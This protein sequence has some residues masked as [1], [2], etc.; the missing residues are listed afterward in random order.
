MVFWPNKKQDVMPNSQKK[1]SEWLNEQLNQKWFKAS[2]MRARE[3]IRLLNAQASA[4]ARQSLGR[5]SRSKREDPKTVANFTATE[6]MDEMD[7][8]FSFCDDRLRPYTTSWL[9]LWL[10]TR[11]EVLKS[12]L[13][14]EWPFQ[15][16]LN[17]A[18]A[19]CEAFVEDWLLDWSITTVWSIFSLKDW[20][21]RNDRPKEE[22]K[23]WEKI[24]SDL[25]TEEILNQIEDKWFLE[26]IE[27]KEV[28]Q[29]EN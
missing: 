12:F 27:Q 25:T 11:R 28:I 8:Y 24:L 16:A 26:V 9:A 15:N 21:N 3:E 2:E 5:Q 18:W 23:I 19:R 14:Q 17:Y 1:N 10:W 4:D 22:N 20:H 29:N 6:L 7:L 13:T